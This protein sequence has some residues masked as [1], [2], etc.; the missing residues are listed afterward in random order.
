[1]PSLVT[2]RIFSGSHKSCLFLQGSYLQK[3][4]WGL[5]SSSPEPINQVNTIKLLTRL[6][7]HP[8]AELVHSQELRASGWNC[9]A[10]HRFSLSFP[11]WSLSFFPLVCLLFGILC[12]FEAALG[13]PRLCPHL[14]LWGW[15]KRMLSQGGSG[16]RVQSSQVLATHTP[17]KFKSQ[18]DL[19]VEETLQLEEEVEGSGPCL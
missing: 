5:I 19:E 1:M 14:L 18:Q 2:L 10:I 9:G 17:C 13:D 15:V 12:H 6:S 11:E 7:F 8:P 4:T 3:T 16:P